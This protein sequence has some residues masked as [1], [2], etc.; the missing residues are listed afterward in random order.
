[1]ARRMTLE[2]ILRDDDDA[3]GQ[4]IRDW[5]IE[6]DS[7]MLTIRPHKELNFIIIRASD[8]KQFADDL[9]MMA[10]QESKPCK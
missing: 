5:I 3:S 1:M 10:A 7:G 4:T 6:E 2:R 9:L 8:A